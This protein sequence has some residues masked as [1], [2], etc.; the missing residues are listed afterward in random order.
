MIAWPLLQYCKEHGIA[1]H[2]ED[3]AVA[4]KLLTDPK[5]G[6]IC[7]HC[8]SFVPNSDPRYHCIICYNDDFDLCQKCVDDGFHCLDNDHRL[9]KISL[10]MDD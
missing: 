3:M 5:S 2:N 4:A 10:E 1:I 6:I 8:D 9:I 7:D